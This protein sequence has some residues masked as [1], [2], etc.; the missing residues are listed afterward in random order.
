MDRGSQWAGGAACL[1]LPN[2]LSIVLERKKQGPHSLKVKRLNN[3][4]K[5]L[6]FSSGWVLFLN[7]ESKRSYDINSSARTVQLFKV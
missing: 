5:K 4:F 2:F 3:F 6:F 1:R 7:P